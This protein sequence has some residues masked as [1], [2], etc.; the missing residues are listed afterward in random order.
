MRMSRCPGPRVVAL[1]CFVML[2]ARA[3][4]AEGLVEDRAPTITISAGA[5]YPF[6]LLFEVPGPLVQGWL[7]WPVHEHV[8]LV[9]T[10]DTGFVIKSGVTRFLGALGGGV[11]LVASR[12]VPV[13]AQVG[14]GATGYVERIGIMLPARDVRAVDHGAMLTS[15][16]AIGVSVASWQFAISYHRNLAISGPQD[17]LYHGEEGQRFDGTAMVSIGRQL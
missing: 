1:G 17:A 4:A 15:D 7:A 3:A 5:V 10:V 13:W 6:F 16:F 11:R 12:R 2:A 14:L 9:A 8:D